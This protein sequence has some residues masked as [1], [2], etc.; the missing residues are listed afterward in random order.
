MEHIGLNREV[1]T[2]RVALVEDLKELSYEG[3]IS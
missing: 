2:L 1:V 3:M